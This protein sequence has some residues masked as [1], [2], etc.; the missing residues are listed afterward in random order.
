MNKL[1]S[2]I[3]KLDQVTE[4]SLDKAV[5]SIV[6]ARQT[7]LV[8]MNKAQLFSGR[9]AEGEPLGFYKNERYAAFKNYENPAPGFGIM[10][11][12]LTGALYGAWYANTDRFPIT[13]GSKDEKYDRLKQ[14]NPE[15]EGLDQENLET[16]RQEIKPE[17]QD[18]FKSLLSV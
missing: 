18:Y 6:A 3:S 12:K 14:I 15:G 17:I 5:L 7:E 16:L 4:E 2:I 11:W 1:E 9:D 10:D 8:E 13:F